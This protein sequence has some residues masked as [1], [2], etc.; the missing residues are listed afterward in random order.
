MFLIHLPGFDLNKFEKSLKNNLSKSKRKKIINEALKN[1]CSIK[2][3]SLGDAIKISNL[4]IPEH[5][6]ILTDD[7]DLNQISEIQAG[8]VFIGTE[9]SAVWEIIVQDHPMLFRQEAKEDLVHKF[10]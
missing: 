6:E 8:A 5:L 7:I 10:H 3:S 2:A 9:A 1:C 4:I